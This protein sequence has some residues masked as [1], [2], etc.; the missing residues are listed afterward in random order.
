[1][2]EFSNSLRIQLLRTARRNELACWIKF[3]GMKQP[4]TDELI[5]SDPIAWVPALEL[6][7]TQIAFDR[8]IAKL[9]GERSAQ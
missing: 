6:I 1:M 4:I 7:D 3:P 9:S 8:F 2:R 5:A